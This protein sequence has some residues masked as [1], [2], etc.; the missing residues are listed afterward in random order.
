MK[1][2]GEMGI[3][4][5]IGAGPTTTGYLCPISPIEDRGLIIVDIES[6]KL[7]ENIIEVNNQK[8]VEIQDETSRHWKEMIELSTY[9][10]GKKPE[11]KLNE[12]INIIE[13]FELIE[14]KKSHLSKWERDEVV[15]LFNKKYKLWK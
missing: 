15:R 10:W 14:V 8:Y 11:R 2:L 5:H 4:A 9:D 3:A 13:E 1:K 7:V 6:V 12:D